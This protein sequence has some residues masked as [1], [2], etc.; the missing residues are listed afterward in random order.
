MDSLKEKLNSIAE[1]MSNYW[2][3]EQCKN[4]YASFYVWSRQAKKGE[5]IAIP[6]VSEDKPNDEYSL[7]SQ[8]I[9]P[10]WTKDQA[11]YFF[12]NLMRQLPILGE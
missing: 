8:R 11:K 7:S 10:G 5:K 6:I 1:T 12:Y 4:V 2:F 9:S 3:K